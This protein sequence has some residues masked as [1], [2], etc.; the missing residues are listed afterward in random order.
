MSITL[1]NADVV[2]AATAGNIMTGP[3]N[4]SVQLTKVTL[5]NTSAAAVTYTL[6]RVANGGSAGATNIIGQG[7]IAANSTAVAQLSGHT[8]TAGQS[9]QGLA[10]TASVVVCNASWVQ[11][12]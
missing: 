11:T 10:S 4:E 1:P 3:V 12:P 9:L 2:L 5:N 8:I 7:T 6:Y